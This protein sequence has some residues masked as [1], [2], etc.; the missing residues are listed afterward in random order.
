[1]G[2]K[3]SV[4]ILD[5]IAGS[6]RQGLV[7][8][9]RVARP[10]LAKMVTDDAAALQEFQAVSP[11]TMW[12]A[13]K[14]VE[15]QEW[16]LD[17]PQ[18]GAQKLF[19]TMRGRGIWPYVQIVEEL[20]E[21]NPEDDARWNEWATFFG[22]Y[23]D[24]VHG[25]GKKVIA[26]NFGVG[27]PSNEEKT[28]WRRATVQ[29]ALAKADYIGYHG[30]NSVKL[31]FAKGLTWNQFRWR[32]WYDL[33]PPECHKPI[34]LTECGLDDI[35]DLR[36]DT[37]SGGWKEHAKKFWSLTGDEAIVTELIRQIAWMDAQLQS[38]PEAYG[39][40]WFCMGTKKWSSY[41]ITPGSLAAQ[42]LA[43][44][45]AS[46]S[47]AT[48][49]VTPPPITPEGWVDL[50][51]VL[52][53][54]G[55]YSTRPLEAVDMIVI[56]ESDSSRDTTPKQIAEYHIGPPNNW[57]GCGYHFVIGKDG[58]IYWCNG[59]EAMSYHVS[60]HNRHTIGICLPGSFMAGKDRE[61]TT[62]QITAT[63]K[64]IAD[65]RA[66]LGALG[67]VG[68]KELM[69]RDCP[70]DTWHVWRKKL[71]IAQDQSAEMARLTGL[72]AQ[73]GILAGQR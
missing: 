49:P 28:W 1:M 9:F 19:D 60:D 42:K 41:D 16:Y 48:P 63:K 53:T 22:L 8:F 34:I 11:D 47:G 62:A 17:H 31:D 56:H 59:L 52:P 26:G 40:T 33:L 10:K 64:L 3:V 29:A 32:L 30:Y 44:Y 15:N 55:T 65:L 36:P 14:V 20:N 54:H 50:R 71:G 46:Q 51:A 12:I 69:A 61:P 2:S 18:E 57:P 66:K 7:D 38:F 43:T 4:Q 70:G 24:L 72:L 5:V 68:H 27:H 23:A 25:A 45:I 21:I 6:Q 58:A 35:A 37:V 73:I 67:V 13:R 39:A